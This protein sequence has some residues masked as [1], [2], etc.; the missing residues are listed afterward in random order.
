M[1][2]LVG[3][4][5][6]EQAELLKM[7]LGVNDNAVMITTDPE[8]LLALAK[9]PQR[10]DVMLI[11]T[12]HPDHDAA[13]SIFESLLEAQPGVP[14]VG[15]C[16]QDG[17]YRIARYMTCGMRSYLIRDENGD[18]M[19]LAQAIL[20]SAVHQVQTERERQVS[21]QLRK[22]VESVR[23][24]QE[25]IIPQNINTPDG[26]SVSA[27]YESSQIRVLGSQPVIMA[28]GDYYEAFTLAND[29]IV[30]LIG[31]ASGHGMKAC[32]S[33]F[34]MHT[35]IRMIQFQEY[36]DASRLV[37][38]INTQLCKQSIISNEGGFIT[39]LYGVLNPETREFRWA[40][41]G[42]NMPLVHNL[43]TDEIYEVAEPEDASG[44][45]IGIFEEAEY[46]TQSTIIPPNSRLMLYTDGLVEAF[47]AN[48]DGDHSEFG[49]EGVFQ[50]L[51]NNRD[52]S[53]DECLDSLFRDSYQFTKG[54][55]RHDDTSVLLVQCK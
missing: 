54:A 49:M 4:D 8:Q 33:I 5:D 35:L 22:E 45:P 9:G 37:D 23:E 31:D 11:T 2:I 27:R 39:L 25:S 19:F 12:S 38:Y 10:W 1:K 46:S 43:S 20:D 40:S 13:F 3:W 6:A 51:K 52:N 16:P 50:T 42:H 36:Q 26:Y 29:Q 24:L 34:T 48:Q 15:A 47:P 53:L 7:Y 41:A 28:G 32:M 21:E 44:L 18:Y 17:V 30:T 55:G 14:I